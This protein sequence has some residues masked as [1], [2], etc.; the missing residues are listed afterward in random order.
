MR[1]SSAALVLCDR[2]LRPAKEN[3][4]AR[5]LVEL[6]GSVG[7]EEGKLARLLLDAL[8]GACF[9]DTDS[10]RLFARALSCVRM[11][12]A[13]PLTNR[14]PSSVSGLS[15]SNSRSRA[16]PG[17][18]L[19]SLQVL[20]RPAPADCVEDARGSGFLCEQDTLPGLRVGEITSATGPVMH[21]VKADCQSSKLV[22]N[23]S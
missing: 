16:S 20:H 5:V 21:D 13:S 22:C 3:A 23:V 11:N 18:H 15:I 19:L 2:K 12:E 6:P 9:F 1:V 14:A 17:K 8:L 4:V 10:C 7:D